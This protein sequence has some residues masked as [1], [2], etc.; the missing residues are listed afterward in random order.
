M[1]GRAAR[2]TSS[3][4]CSTPCPPRPRRAAR[5][6][7]ACWSRRRP[8]AGR[9]PTSSCPDLRPRA[10]AAPRWRS[11]ARTAVPPGLARRRAD[12]RPA[13]RAGRRASR[14]RHGRRAAACSGAARARRPHRAVGWDLLGELVYGRHRPE[15][16]Q[17]RA[18]HRAGRWPPS[19]TAAATCR[20]RRGRRCPRER[21]DALVAYGEFLFSGG[22]A[23]GYCR[24]RRAPRRRARAAPA[25]GRRPR[26]A[27][28]RGAVRPCVDA[29]R[30]G[31]AARRA[32]TATVPRSACPRRRT[33]TS[34][35][36]WPRA[37]TDIG[38]AAR[39]VAALR[40]DVLFLRRGVPARPCRT[41]TRPSRWPPPSSTT[42]STDP[43][44]RR[45]SGW[46]AWPT[47]SPRSCPPQA[48]A[49]EHAPRRRGAAG[50]DPAGYAAA[51]DELVGAHLAPA[52]RAAHG[53]P[54]H[55]ARLGLARPGLDAHRRRRTGRVRAWPGSRRP[56]GCSPSCPRRTRRTSSWWS[57]PAGVGVD[58][59]LL[60]AAAPRILAVCRP[61]DP[62]R[63]NDPAQPAV[64]GVRAG[65]PWPVGR[66]AGPGR[67][68][69]RT[70]ALRSVGAREA[71]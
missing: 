65:H 10:R 44:V 62:D 29:L 21:V 13:R 32:S 56:S 61:G 17:P 9:G 45:P 25:A 28:R 22:R 42:A 51:V 1:R 64:P 3:T 67:P 66:E 8:P 49:P 63:R 11:C 18:V 57:T 27:D 31:R 37:L 50:R 58:R 69:H 2:R 5:A 43:R 39:S 16:D 19:T 53:R 35:P 47:T 60:G 71:L 52:R 14:G 38:A 23:R 7:Q 40:H 24:A 36:R 15:F 48:T 41:S 12:R 68:A 20:R 46:T 30:A 55:R 59:A 70:P 4:G 6:A 26:P 33:R 34:S 54:A